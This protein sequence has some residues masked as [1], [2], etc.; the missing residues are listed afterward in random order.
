MTFDLRRRRTITNATKI[1]STKFLVRFIQEI[2]QNFR[3]MAKESCTMCSVLGCKSGY[4][5]YDPGARFKTPSHVSFHSYP[6]DHF[7]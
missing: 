2:A 7:R 1:K 3:C 5:K 6:K 4:D